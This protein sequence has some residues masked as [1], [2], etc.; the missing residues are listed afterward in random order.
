MFEFPFHWWE[1]RYNLTA[2]LLVSNE[3]TFLEIPLQNITFPINTRLLL[4]INITIA[5]YICVNF[6]LIKCKEKS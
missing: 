6:V 3:A 1:I 5:N 4:S 2:L